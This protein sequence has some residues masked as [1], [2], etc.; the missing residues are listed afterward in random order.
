MNINEVF[1]SQLELASLKTICFIC[2][3]SMGT[4]R[5]TLVVW[6]RKDIDS[7]LDSYDFLGKDVNRLPRFIKK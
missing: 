4:D 3:E 2:L 7:I 6:N 1:S 5:E